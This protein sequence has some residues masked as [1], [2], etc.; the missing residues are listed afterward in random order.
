MLPGEIPRVRRKITSS[1]GL[2]LTV[3]RTWGHE[4]C[5]GGLRDVTIVRMRSC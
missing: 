3:L 4:H 5:G 1:A 2:R